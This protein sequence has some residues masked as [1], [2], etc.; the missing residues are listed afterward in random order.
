MKDK[1]EKISERLLRRRVEV[2][3]TREE[4]A[5]RVGL[6]QRAI[7]RM[8]SGNSPVLD[9][10]LEPLAEALEC[11]PEYLRS[12]YDETQDAVF[13]FVRSRFPVPAIR[14]EFWQHLNSAPSFREANL[15]DTDLRILADSFESQKQLEDE[16]DLFGLDH[17]DSK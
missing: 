11:T 7:A 2:G 1:E 4:L 15:S 13:R 14:Q 10:F 12:G 9:E 16:I 8:E 17:G 6:S 5:S 3:L